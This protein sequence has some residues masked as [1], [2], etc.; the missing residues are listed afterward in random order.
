[1]VQTSQLSTLTIMPLSFPFFYVAFVFPLDAFDHRFWH[2]SLI[3]I[4]FFALRAYL[5]MYAFTIIIANAEPQRT[6]TY[7]ADVHGYGYG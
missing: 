5:L 1:M 3:R 2:D 7:Y 4:P 6:D